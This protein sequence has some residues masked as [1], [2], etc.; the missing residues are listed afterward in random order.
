M[1]GLHK[2][3][4]QGETKA[5]AGPQPGEVQQDQQ[6]PEDALA[7]G[8]A[9]LPVQGVA[10]VE[11]S[12]AFLERED[13]RHA[14]AAVDAE[15]STR[16]HERARVV[17]CEEATHFPDER[18]PMRPRG[19]RLGPAPGQEGA[20]DVPAARLPSRNRCSAAASG[21][22]HVACGPPVLDDNVPRIPLG[23][24]LFQDGAYAAQQAH[25]PF[26]SAPRSKTFTPTRG[27]LARTR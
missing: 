15:E 8:R 25:A 14:G 20:H 4:G 13:P 23:R 3:C 17:E 9:A 27:F 24:G 26:L 1:R 5:L 2:G 7:P 6:R 19:L 22:D 11:E 18:Q 16:G 10:G 21:D 12:A